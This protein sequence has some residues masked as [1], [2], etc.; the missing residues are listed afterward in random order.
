MIHFHIGIKSEYFGGK[1]SWE[2][3]TSKKLKKKKSWKVQHLKKLCKYKEL[4]VCTDTSRGLCR[5]TSRQIEDLFPLGPTKTRIMKIYL[6]NYSNLYQAVI[7]PWL[8][9]CCEG[10]GRT[11]ITRVATGSCDEEVKSFG[12]WLG[13]IEQRRST[14]YYFSFFIIHCGIWQIL[15]VIW[16]EL[17][18]ISKF[19]YKC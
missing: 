7:G 19:F 11:R 10:S 13:V 1:I 9:Y 6:D 14:S 4:G 3:V 16:K 8:S 5:S 15:P 17:Q 2:M 18:N 12:A